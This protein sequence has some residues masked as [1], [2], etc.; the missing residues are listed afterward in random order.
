ML[1]FL[2][3]QYVVINR[4][5]RIIFWLPY[6]FWTFLKFQQKNC[7]SFSSKFK[8]LQAFESFLLINRK[9]IEKDE[10]LI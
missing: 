3:K 4:D 5:V 1:H 9:S 2:F 10:G 6:A 7:L 8:G